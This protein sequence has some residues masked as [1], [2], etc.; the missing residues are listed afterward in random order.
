M[1]RTTTWIFVAAAAMTATAASADT[2]TFNATLGAGAPTETGSVATGKM[3]MRVNTERKRVSVD[4]DVKGISLDA[5]S[6]ALVARP[7]GP[8]HFH[9]YMSDHHHGDVVLV[10]PV[11]YGPDYKATARGFHVAM[12]DYDYATGAKLLGS[13][14]DFGGF[15]AALK[16]GQ[17]ILNIHTDRFGDG[18]ISGTVKAA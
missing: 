7:I 16:S 3:R 17:V 6:D 18:E 14:L 11:P 9:K 13:D 12:R 8:V 1:V 10:L 15:V 2:L 4:L 5:L